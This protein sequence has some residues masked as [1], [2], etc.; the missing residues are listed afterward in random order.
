MFSV[1]FWGAWLFDGFGIGC[2]VWVMLRVGVMFC[3]D[4]WGVCH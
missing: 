2:V 4:V 1:E 3:V